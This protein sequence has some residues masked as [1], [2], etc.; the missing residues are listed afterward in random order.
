MK[1]TD[2]CKAGVPELRPGRRWKCEKQ[3]GE[4]LQTVKPLLR[5]KWT[6]PRVAISHISPALDSFN[7]VCDKPLGLP[8]TSLRFI[9]HHVFRCQ[10]DL[11]RQKPNYVTSQLKILKRFPVKTVFFKLLFLAA[12]PFL[13]TQV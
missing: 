12:K 1:R 6:E 3:P 10:S 2:Y 4:D 7:S 5:R 13:Q 8:I 11:L 9:L